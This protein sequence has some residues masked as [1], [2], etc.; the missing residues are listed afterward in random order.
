[1]SH[2]ALFFVVAVV[3]GGV[4]TPAASG[5]TGTVTTGV[6]AGPV[7]GSDAGTNPGVDGGNDDGPFGLDAR[8]SN[9]TC[10]APEKPTEPSGVAV[11]RVFTSLTFTAPALLS[12]PP[13]D[14]SRI[15]ILER[16]G[17]IRH[18]PND[19]AAS[20]AQVALDIQSQVALTGEGGLL[21]MAFH[22]DWASRKE[23]YVSY[24]RAGSGG[25]PLRSV[26]SRF[27]SNDNGATFAPSSEEIL[28]QL[29]Q[30]YSN[31]NGGG[32]AFGPDGFL[33]IGFGDGGS[34]GDPL[35][36]GQRT[37]TLLGKFVRI[38]VDVPF[39]QK[40]RIPPTN[41]FAAAGEPCNLNASAHTSTATTHCAEIYALGFRNPWRWSFDRDTGELWAGD[42]GQNAWE[43][44]DR[45]V[46][47]GNYGWKVREG[48]HCFSPANG[49]QTAGLIEPIV[50]YDRSQGV[51]I[52][53][54][55]V[56]RG[57]LVPGLVG[58]FIFGD[59]ESG[60]VWAVTQ[61]PS[62]GEYSSTLLAD[63]DIN[64]ASFGQTLDGEV[65]ALGLTDGR[66]YQ[67]R[68]TA[69]P[70]PVSFPQKL[71]QTGCFDPADPTK[72][73]PAMIP[74]DV[75]A[76]LWS[77]GADKERF[78][79]IPDGTTIEVGADGDWDFPVGSVLAKTFSLG[80]KRVETRLFMRHPDGSWAGYSYEWDD[81]Q[82][83]ATLLPA[84]K[85][86]TVGGQSWHFPSRAECMM[87]HTE[88]AGRTLGPE[89]AQLNRTL[90]Y[91][92]GRA[93]NQ[94]HTLEGLGFFTSALG[95]EPAKLPRY[96][97]PFGQ[98]PLE[99]RARAYLHAN[100]SGCH[101]EG[102]GRSTQD[103]RAS[104]TLEQ[105][106]A[107]DV[108]PS[109]GDLGIANARLIAPGEPDRSMLSVRM[110]R[111]DANRMPPLGTSVA[112]TQGTQLVDAWI[113][114]LQGCAP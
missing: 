18:F 5:C 106:H 55:Y 17:T 50:E 73:L 94:L 103:L 62:S 95:S 32:I 57:S 61:S 35:N 15:W 14:P 59:Y 110:H 3:F 58:R 37:N 29:D 36:S 96:E 97:E 16:T 31:H 88:L 39:A 107:C 46:L 98:G 72:P 24:T 26:I 19:A 48:A 20:Q 10:I 11:E 56:Y 33:Y 66:I 87:C 51:S 84:S 23:L 30:P 112:D 38:D 64:I 70:G 71:S 12:Q 41:P 86:K 6:D 65:Y 83:D 21:G 74:Y 63:T 114:S 81:A 60:R 2:R 85:R 13:G 105:M 22:P 109:L 99:G 113:T 89:T 78:F 28:L 53:G 108:A 76:A 100:C 68:P 111:L 43:E 8:P 102:F 47:G 104:G 91:P 4:L 90:Q 77:D 7:G 42:V 1:M 49:C 27:K 34:G 69:P 82:T 40:Y 45:V 9:P 67:L 75:N 79:A 93:R 25:S 52:T 80:G 101:R 44:I 54:G 92:T